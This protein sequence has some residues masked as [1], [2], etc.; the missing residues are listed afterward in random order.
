MKIK[1][2]Y[3]VDNVKLLC[4]VRQTGRCQDEEAEEGSRH[5][6]LQGWNN[7]TEDYG[8]NRHQSKADC[9]QLFARREYSTKQKIAVIIWRKS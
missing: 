1:L 5:P 6:A 8:N 2:F 3:S 9:I 4:Q 7:Y